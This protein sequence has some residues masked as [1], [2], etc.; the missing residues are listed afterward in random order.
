MPETT[1]KTATQSRDAKKEDRLR[2]AQSVPESSVVEP[3][4]W[5]RLLGGSFDNPS[6]DRHSRVV[7]DPRLSQPVNS[8]HRINVLTHLQA[9]RG[10]SYVQRLLRNEGSIRHP[11]LPPLQAAVQRDITTPLEE[12][13]EVEEKKPAKF[14]IGG[15]SVTV[16]H[17]T[18]TKAKSMKGEAQTNID[19]SWKLPKWTSE[20]GKVTKIEGSVQLKVTIKTEYGAGAGPE[21]PSAYGKGPTLGHHEASHGLDYLKFM[22]D[23]PPP[24]FEG[25]EGMTKKQYTKAV[26]KYTKEA[27]D[28]LA[29]TKQYSQE[30]TDCVGVKA[31][32]C[33]PV[34]KS[35][36]SEVLQKSPI[37]QPIVHLSPS[38]ETQIQRSPGLWESAK[39]WA[40]EKALGAVGVDQKQ[41]MGL[42]SKAGS[43]ISEIFKDPGKFVNTLI[44]A[45]GQGFRQFA[46]N[47]GKHLMAGLMNWLLGTMSKAGV[48][49]PRDL[50]PRSLL[51]LVLQVLGISVDKIK[52]KLTA[53][54]GTKN[55]SRLETAWDILSTFM[56]DGVGGLW[57]MLKDYLSDLKDSVIE[58][59]K[60]WLMIEVVKAAVM[61]IVSMFNPVTGLINVIKMI[62][63]VITFLIE[64]A[65]QI[66]QL[67]SA[68][69]SSVYEL[70]MGN[71]KQAADKIE[72]TLASLI[73][74]AIGFL[75][76]L[77]GI[78]GLADKI[79]EII[80]KLQ[81][82]V[83]KAVDAVIGKV[84]GMVTKLLG[85]GKAA[86][87]GTA[88]GKLYGKGKAKAAELYGKGKAM[89]E[90][91]KEKAQE[92]FEK[93]KSKAAGALEKGAAKVG[94]DRGSAVVKMVRRDVV[95]LTK[96]K[97]RTVE[98]F[99]AALDRVYQTYKPQGLKSLAVQGVKR[100][101]PEKPFTI[102]AVASPAEPVAVRTWQQIFEVG[103]EPQGEAERF[104]YQE[105]TTYAMLVVDGRQIGQTMASKGKEKHAERRLLDSRDWQDVLAKARS[106]ALATPPRKTVIDFVVN[107]APCH[108]VVDRPRGPGE[109]EG[110][111][112]LLCDA[113]KRF[114]A[115]PGGSE[116][117]QHITFNLVATGVYEQI[118]GGA[119]REQGTTTSSDL[120]RL[121][122]AGW[123]LHGLQVGKEQKPFGRQLTT[124]IMNMLRRLETVKKG[125]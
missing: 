37:D 33:Q 48:E 58:Q 45:V 42:L 14:K 22:T 55:M 39:R 10:N 34:E 16:K 107:R 119:P 43:A 117:R 71:V 57:E 115:L 15:I 69:T 56:R 32:F 88:A 31:S 100:D 62:Y 23:N 116:A 99:D 74:I 70:A 95:K 102:V 18:T 80:K 91:G 26:K 8:R 78:T 11:S 121:A 67:F 25:Q 94:V 5:E 59:V 105:Q 38:Q 81:I 85:K 113:L 123:R 72:Q 77:L 118:G 96:S 60:S 27:K 9:S 49:V 13:A 76:S 61:K 87:A 103:P 64:K 93:V 46:E 90:K 82:R 7:T 111:V 112:R 106:D 122:N 109:K 86:F 24:E 3:V 28:Y 36:G 1:T 73:P 21:S 83:D 53:V 63:N 6:V 110:C 51:Q 101:D 125:I 124:G 84:A 30:Q 19:L 98:A 66:M 35:A 65:R 47:I 97:Y 120:L 89:Y 75:A 20:K 114:H 92:T 50:S 52:T 12:H 44:K 2:Q 4:V 40:F 29:K 17:D 68:I 41:V 79:K 104:E 108:S 54:I